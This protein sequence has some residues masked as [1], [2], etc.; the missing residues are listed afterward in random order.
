MQPPILWEIRSICLLKVQQQRENGWKTDRWLATQVLCSLQDSMLNASQDAD[1]EEL[2]ELYTEHRVLDP[3]VL[4]GLLILRAQGTDTRNTYDDG[5]QVLQQQRCNEAIKQIS[6]FIASLEVPESPK[7]AAL[8]FLLRNTEE[9]RHAYQF[10]SDPQTD[11][12]QFEQHWCFVLWE[13]RAICL[14]ERQKQELNHEQVMQ[15]AGLAADVIVTT[16]DCVQLILSGATELATEGMM[17]A[18]DLVVS[19]FCLD[20][21]SARTEAFTQHDDKVSVVVRTCSGAAKRATD[22]ARTVAA[23]TSRKIRTVSAHHLRQA[24]KKLPVPATQKTNVEAAT[25]VAMACLGA[26]ATVGEAVFQ[27]TGDLAK[28]ATK[29]ASNI[30]QH[31]YGDTAGQ[32]VQDVGDTIGNVIRT[33]KHVALLTGTTALPRSVAKA[34]GKQHLGDRTEYVNSVNDDADSL[35]AEIGGN[36]YNVPVAHYTKDSDHI[37][38][39]ATSKKGYQD[40]TLS[41]S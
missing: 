31:K 1:F 34:T 36:V 26:I 3:P 29:A 24:V 30:V 16:A 38:M 23:G 25:H 9:A 35:I 37:S 10:C 33:A 41:L 27:S 28:G 12:S 20:E 15:V 4:A 32:V 22:Q 18:S 13:F 14:Y 5:A 39:S 6:V 19:H 2:Y 8:G 11:T 40:R 17:S 7:I 21:P